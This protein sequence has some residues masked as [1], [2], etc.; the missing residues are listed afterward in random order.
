MEG[1]ESGV[2]TAV[3]EPAKS[4]LLVLPILLLPDVALGLRLPLF[5]KDK[6]RDKL[7]S[8]LRN[9]PTSLPSPSV[10][11]GKLRSSSTTSNA[12]PGFITRVISSKRSS[13]Y[14]GVSI[15]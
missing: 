1:I 3:M 8:L 6:D 14:S 13:H 11:P 4:E 7:L 2:V 12:A 10:R 15:V 5:E 9:V